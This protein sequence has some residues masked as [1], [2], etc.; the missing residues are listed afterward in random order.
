MNAVDVDGESNKE[1]LEVIDVTME[2][3]G[4]SVEIG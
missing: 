2:S 4:T 3:N 1:A